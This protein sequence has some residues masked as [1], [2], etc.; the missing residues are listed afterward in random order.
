MS[1]DLRGGAG[2]DAT[3]ILGEGAVADAEEAVLDLPVIAGE[4]EQSGGVEALLGQAGDGVDDLA[5]AEGLGLAP[6][7]DA[8]DAQEARPA[9]IEAGGQPRVNGNEAGLDAAVRLLDRFGASPVGRVGRPVRG[10]RQSG[11]P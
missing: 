9:L 7:L 1:E 4:L 2:S 8:A 6:A 11:E 5:R 3:S 10:A